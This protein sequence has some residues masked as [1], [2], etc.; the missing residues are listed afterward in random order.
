MELTLRPFA[1][2]GRRRGGDTGER[3]ALRTFREAA[4]RAGGYQEHLAA[5]GVDPGAVRHLDEVPYTDKR[6]VFGGDIG[7]WLIGGRVTDA[8][9]LLTSSGQSGLFSVG[10]TSH[11]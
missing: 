6:S 9:E 1:A 2:L 5:H 11:A 7:R 3:A 4:R 10:I 8:A